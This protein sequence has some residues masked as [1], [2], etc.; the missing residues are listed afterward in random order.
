MNDPEVEEGVEILEGV[1]FLLANRIVEM[2]IQVYG[3]DSS[4][5]S[6]LREVYLKQNNYYVVLRT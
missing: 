3:L 4:Q 6:A 2:A 1:W 5:A